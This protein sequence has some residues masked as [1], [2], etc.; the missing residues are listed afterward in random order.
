[1]LL[2][3]NIP[4]LLLNVNSLAF[5]RLIVNIITAELDCMIEVVIK[6]TAMLF[7]VVEVNFSNLFLMF[8]NDRVI[9]LLLKKSIE[10][11]K[12][13]VPPISKVNVNLITNKLY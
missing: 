5:I 1:M 10:Y 6:P 9:K 12:R 13:I 8:V 4:M 7:G 11:I 2:P 3:S